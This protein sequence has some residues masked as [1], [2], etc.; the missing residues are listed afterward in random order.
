MPSC[1]LKLRNNARARNPQHRHNHRVRIRACETWYRRP[2]VC[3]GE[4]RRPHPRRSNG[5]LE[6]AVAHC[7]AYAACESF[8]PIYELPLLHLGERCGDVRTSHAVLLAWRVRVMQLLVEDCKRLIQNLNAMPKSPRCKGSL[9]R[10]L[11]FRLECNR[12]CLPGIAPFTHDYW[13]WF[14]NSITF[15]V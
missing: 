3:R 11:M 4:P 12:H 1:W 10:L 6:P 2:G 8:L 15:R 5:A 7:G 9:D 13:P 14:E